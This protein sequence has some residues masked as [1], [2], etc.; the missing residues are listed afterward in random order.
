MTHILVQFFVINIFGGITAALYAGFVLQP[1]HTGGVFSWYHTPAAIMAG[2]VLAALGIALVNQKEVRALFDVASDRQGIHEFDGQMVNH[3]QKAALG[4]P[5][6]ATG[7]DF[8]AWTLTGLIAGFLAPIAA[9]RPGPVDLLYCLKQFLGIVLLGGGMTCLVLF[10]V[11]ENTWQPCIAKFFPNG[12]PPL[13]H[14]SPAITIKKRFLIAVLGIVVIPL[15][16][17]VITLFSAQTAIDMATPPERVRIMAAL[18]RELLFISSEAAIVACILSFLVLK[19]ISVPLSGINRA[20]RE[21]EKNNLN[22]RAAICADDELGELAQGVN[23]MIGNLQQCRQ[24]KECFGRYMCREI[25]DEVLAGNASLSGEM[26]RVTLL[27]SDLRNFTGLVETNHPRKVVGILN[28]YFNAMTQAVKDHKG[29]VLQYVGDEIE[30]VFGAPGEY[31]DHPEMAVRA[32]LAMRKNLAELNARLESQ[33]IPALSHGIGIHSGA[34]LAGNIGNEER[35]SYTLVGDTVNTASRIEG[36]A[37]EYKT[38][39]IISQTTHDLLT[40][41]YAMHQLPPVIVKGKKNGL[42]LY[43]LKFQ[44]PLHT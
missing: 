42:I 39:I 27:F 24:A 1:G 8:A 3:L 34:V 15:P 10:F 11:I 4:F 23:R 7:A 21:V 32:A 12:V 26:K 30:A 40:G 13:F 16:V 22:T 14:S 25:Q 33:G 2:F 6:R 20:I 36:L 9:A 29:L 28:R 18:S 43:K 35:M 44:Q 38:D 37:R 17:V 19:S 41:S 5:M 31:D